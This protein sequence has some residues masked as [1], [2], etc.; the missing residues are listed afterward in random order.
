M[1]PKLRNVCFGPTARA[2]NPPMR[3]ADRPPRPSNAALCET[4]EARRLFAVD[5][6]LENGV[7][8]IYGHDIFND[9]FAVVRWFDLHLQVDDIQLWDVAAPGGAALVGFWPAAN[10][11]KI[12]ANLRGGD[13]K[14]IVES[15]DNVSWG[16]ISVNKPCELIGGTHDD[17]I[18]SGDGDDT[19][20]GNDGY[21]VIVEHDGNNTVYGG[22]GNDVISGGRGDDR[23]FGGIGNDNMWDTFSTDSDVLFGEVGNDTLNIEDWENN[24]FMSGGDGE[25]W[26]TG[27]DPGDAIAG[28]VEHR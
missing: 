23:L 12:V 17:T 20:Y 15:S 4:L 3:E 13:D 19:I 1:L 25:D 21:D 14:I 2:V 22:P 8:K 6:E 27:S 18:E 26:S 7:L 28:D 10:V 16:T 11:T 5:V 9:D 24:D